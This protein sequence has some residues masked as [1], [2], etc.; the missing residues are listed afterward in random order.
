[1]HKLAPSLPLNSVFLC[2]LYFYTRSVGRIERRGF[3]VVSHFKDFNLGAVLRPLPL[4]VYLL[5]LALAVRNDTVT[6]FRWCG[7]N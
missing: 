3:L 5:P 6:L 7:N 4:S 2:L 1:M